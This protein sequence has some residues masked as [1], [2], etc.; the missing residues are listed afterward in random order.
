MRD[1]VSEDVDGVPEAYPVASEDADIQCELSMRTPTSILFGG[2]TFED[3]EENM[4]EITDVNESLF[5][6]FYCSSRNQTLDITHV[7]Q[8]LPLSH[9]SG[10]NFFF[11]F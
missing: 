5:K 10:P 6:L 8:A 9:I 3:R 2:L 7:S 11:N 4:V 1:L